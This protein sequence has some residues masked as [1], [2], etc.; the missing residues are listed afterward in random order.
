MLLVENT[1]YRSVP[2]TLCHYLVRLSSE[3]CLYITLIQT[4][5]RDD[6]R[7]ETSLHAASDSSCPTNV[8]RR[9][10]YIASYQNDYIGHHIVVNF[11]ILIWNVLEENGRC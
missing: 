2:N 7:L 10:L 8:T 6:L 1:G 11:C 4:R 5:I 9:R 3:A